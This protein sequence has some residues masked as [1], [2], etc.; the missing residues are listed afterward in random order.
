MKTPPEASEE[1]RSE[2]TTT[3]GY[4]IVGESVTDAVGQE[5]GRILAERDRLL[6]ML[7]CAWLD[8]LHRAAAGSSPEFARKLTALLATY[9]DYPTRYLQEPPRPTPAP[10]GEASPALLVEFVKAIACGDHDEE[11]HR[12]NT[13]C[14]VCE[15]RSL[16]GH[17][18]VE[19]AE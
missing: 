14:P 15:A 17:A 11:A 3:Q 1:A 2:T 18:P 16:V 12:T 8:M 5:F 9:E 7:R 10:A 13:V 4:R 19:E 6:D